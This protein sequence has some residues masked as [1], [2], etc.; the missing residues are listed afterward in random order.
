MRK[1]IPFRWFARLTAFSLLAGCAAAVPE[2]GPLFGL[3]GDVP[4]SEGEVERLERL[5]DDINAQ[6]VAFVVHLGDIGASRSQACHDEWVQARKLQFGRIA[7]P[8]VLVP[9]DNEWSDCA[10]PLVRLARWR[11]L[12][13]L[14]PSHPLKVETQQGDFCEHVRWEAGGYVFITLNVPGSNNNVRHAEHAPRMAAVL[15]WLEEGAQLARSHEGLV[16]LMQANPFVTL[17]RDGYA[18]LRERLERLGLERPGKAI[19]VHGD[20]HFYRDDEP[21]AGLRRIEV[22]GSPFVSWLPAAIA[23]GGI[24]INGP[25]HR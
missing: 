2:G 16:I 14:T 19:L 22:W 1:P 11:Q 5:I 7:H 10:D 4:Y 12:F 23:G 3:L 18:G 9:G 8:F 20:T 13:C 25:R 17:P 6:P 24:R 15:A 21:L